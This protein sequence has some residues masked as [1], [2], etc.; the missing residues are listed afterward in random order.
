MGFYE[1]VNMSMATCE[2]CGHKLLEMKICPRSGR[3]NI[4]QIDR[5]NG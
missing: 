3:N 4:S 1:G 2:E 5:L